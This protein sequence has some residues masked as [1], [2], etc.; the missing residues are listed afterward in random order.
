MLIEEREGGQ[1][2]MQKQKR[3]SGH[4]RKVIG[5]KAKIRVR[6]HLRKVRTNYK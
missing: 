3:I 2:K 5:Q 6:P 1:D 4:L